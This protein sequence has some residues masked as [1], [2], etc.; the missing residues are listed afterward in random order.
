MTPEE[1]IL[2]KSLVLQ[3]EMSAAD[4]E[5]VSAAIKDRAFFSSRVA[6]ANFLDICQSKLADL[7]SGARN[8][9]GA[10]TSRAE[11]VSAIM[12]AA[13][14][15][16]IA[17]GTD[18]LSD[19][20]SAARANVIVDTNAALAAG[21]VRAEVG[22]TYGARLAFPAQELVRVEAREKPRDWRRIW[23][24][25]GG[26]LYTGRM[27]ALKGDPVWLAISRFGVPYPPFDFNSG[28]GVEDVSF[29]E[30]VE[31]GVIPQGYQPPESSPIKEFNDGLESALNVSGPESPRLKEL[32]SVFGEQ[33][34]FNHHTKSVY[35]DGA[36]IHNVIRQIRADISNGANT[37]S[38]KAK[39]SVGTASGL[40]RKTVGALPKPDAALKLSPS[41][42]LHVLQDHVGV[43]KDSRNIPL[44][45][46]ELG[47][48]GHVWR[49]PDSV[50]AAKDGGWLL[51]KRAA[52]GNLYRL[53]I[54]VEPNGGL[55][56][57]TFYKEKQK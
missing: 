49:N 44:T 18:R 51:T 48:V 13:R 47:L 28:M 41:N 5:V 17:Q 7:L 39:P 25:H 14:A 16:G 9:D 46:R 19:P 22:N 54:S 12:Q 53:V 23:T 30:A 36:M 52:D 10:V 55:V 38:V 1:V 26:R 40:F 31:L 3:G 43:D 35:F 24:E 57:H 8:S 6:S 33:I 4:W 34:Q 2:R 32:Q 27:V 11:A 56:F 42:L 50:E 20:G 15:E 21:Y 45:D 29:D 37:T